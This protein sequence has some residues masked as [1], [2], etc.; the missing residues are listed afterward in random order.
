MRCHS[1]KASSCLRAPLTK[2]R[3]LSKT[4]ASTNK[5][6]HRRYGPSLLILMT[7]NQTDSPKNLSMSLHSIPSP[8]QTALIK[9]R[10]KNLLKISNHW[11]I[12]FGTSVSTNRTFQLQNFPNLVILSVKYSS[13]S[14]VHLVANSI[15]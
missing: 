9:N 11:V 2:T 3:A 4:P 14:L 12:R 15:S 7:K 13:R 6:C 5:R 1:P 10:L 8:K